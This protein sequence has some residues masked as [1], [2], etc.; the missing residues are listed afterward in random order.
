MILN[1]NFSI[2]EPNEIIKE[3]TELL[4]QRLRRYHKSHDKPGVD[5]VK[6]KESA[7]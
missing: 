4:L 3:A 2:D 1:R 5:D 6:I 7:R